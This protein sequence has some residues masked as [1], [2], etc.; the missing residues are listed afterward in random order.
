[1]AQTETKFTPEFMAQQR[2]LTKQ[3]IDL[4][5]VAGD[6]SREMYH[7]GDNSILAKNK[8][9][10]WLVLF[11]FNPNYDCRNESVYMTAAANHYPEALDEIE[12]LRARAVRAERMS[13]TLDTIYAYFTREA[14]EPNSGI[15]T[16]KL[17]ELMTEIE[18]VTGKEEYWP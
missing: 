5:W 15:P 6:K 7:E 18:A 16:E 17:I 8:D 11:K 13:K 4:P 10:D 12:R 3:I 14:A 9:G 2:E 1:M